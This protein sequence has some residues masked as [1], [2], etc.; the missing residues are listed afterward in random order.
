VPAPKPQFP[1]LVWLI[2]LGLL[3]VSVFSLFGPGSGG[4]SSAVIPYSQFQQYLDAGKVKQVT[5]SGDTMRGSLTE[6]MPD[7]KTDFST[8]VVAPDLAGALAKH[9]VEY[10]AAPSNT[11]FGTL[12]SWIIPPLLFVGIWMWASRAMMGGRGGGM[13][14]LGGGLFSIGRSRAKLITA[15]TGIQ[16]TFDDVAGVDE[17]KA[18]LHEIVDFLKRPDEFGRLGAHIPRGILLVGPP[19]TG[20]TLLARAVA[21]E[22]GVPFF[23]TNGAE[24]VEMFVGVGASRVRDLFE[25]ARGSAPCIIFIDELDALGRA[26]GASPMTGQDEKE[27]TL[28]QLLAEMDGFDRSVAIVV[29]AATNR[30]EILDPALLRAGRFDRQVLV[31][32]PDRKGRVDILRIHLKRMKLAADVKIEDVAALTP[33]FTG[34]DLANLANEAAVVATRRGGESLAMDDFTRAIERIVAGL[35]KKSRVLIPKERRIVA[36][37]EM[38]HALVAL[39]IPGS[40]PVQKVSI[41]PRGIGALGYTMQRPV[42]DRFLMS[43]QEL[44]DKMT[45]LLGGRAAEMILGDDVSTGAADDLAKATDIARGIVMRF[46]MDEHLGPVAWDTEQGNFLQDQPGVFWR[47]RRYSDETAHEIDQA[48]RGHVE[49]ARARAVGILQVNRAALDEGAAALLAHETLGADELPKVQ[50]PLPAAAN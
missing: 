13:G 19:G 11:V 22:A 15:E 49:A 36:Y 43:R 26:R 37:H 24:F 38:G 12:L 39:A 48:V 40:D 47:Q 18:E 17:A 5:V 2:F 35:E 41:I 6:K 32:R 33:G 23:S 30:P 34:A 16:T 14:G 44:Q 20:K 28:N 42:D 50:P 3:V 29:L 31:D 25:Q 4:S 8:V 7:G 45:V 1:S 9:G 21:G 46:G 27:Q 10:S